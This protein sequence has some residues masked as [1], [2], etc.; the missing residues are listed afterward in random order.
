M[1]ENSKQKL[2]YALTNA[3]KHFNIRMTTENDFGFHSKD[4][5]VMEYKPTED[6]EAKNILKTWAHLKE[7]G[8]HKEVLDIYE[9]TLLTF[10]FWFD[11]NEIFINMKSSTVF[12]PMYDTC[13]ELIEKICKNLKLTI[14]IV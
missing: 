13:M 12:V 3:N 10:S 7:Q 4:C 14:N 9:S 6:P 8:W 2:I 1:K 5:F 11:K